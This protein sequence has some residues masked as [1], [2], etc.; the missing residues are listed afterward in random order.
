MEILTGRNSVR[1]ALLARR[2]DVRRVVLAEGVVQKGTI[3]QILQLCDELRVPVSRANRRELDRLGGDPKHQGI[4]AQVSS[5]PYVSLATVLALAHQREE[6]PFLLALDLVQD[7]QNVGSLL[8]TAEA[9]EVHGVLLPARRSA[10]ITPAVSRASAGAVEHL[11]VCSVTNLVRALRDLK[12][13][14]IWAVG[15]EDH[16]SAKDYRLADLDLPLVLVLGSEGRG[17]RRLV[18]Q[19]CDLL[20]RIPMR[21][22]IN[23]LNVTVAGSILLYQAWNARQSGGSVVWPTQ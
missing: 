13:R 9:V 23:S 15:V 20:L 19:E 12:S 3:T 7:P 21:G 16:P 8:R 1:E 5:Y 2:R 14:G 18:A 4:A 17:M 11:L 22:R 6:L 10:Q